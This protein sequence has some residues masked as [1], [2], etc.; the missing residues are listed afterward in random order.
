MAH[1]P[2]PPPHGPGS[3]T[4]YDSLGRAVRTTDTPASVSYTHYD[5]DGRVIDSDRPPGGG[6]PPGDDPPDEPHVV[7]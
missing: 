1:V 7:E 6:A 2:P 3:V 4:V 5:G